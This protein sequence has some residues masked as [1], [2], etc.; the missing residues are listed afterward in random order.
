LCQ[1]LIC[2][3]EMREVVEDAYS[4]NREL[5]I[6]CESVRENVVLDRGRETL[7]PEQTI[8]TEADIVTDVCFLPDFPATER[9]GGKAAL[10]Y[11][12]T[13]HILYYG[14]DRQLHSGNARWQGRWET[15]LESSAKILGIPGQPQV[16]AVIGNGVVHVS[17]ELPVEMEAWAQQEIS[18]V[19]GIHGGEPLKQDPS[20]PS[21]MLKRAGQA[22]LWEIAKNS[23][24]TVDAICKANGLQEEPVDSR[25][26]LIPVL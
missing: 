11:P 7:Y 25:M 1:Y 8:N 20:R 14:T 24:S 15:E 10:Q 4:L 2:D 9:T 18:M 13:F 12:G 22:S 6:Q 3:R 5:D 16:Q 17:A 21:L 23:G 26:L 19:T